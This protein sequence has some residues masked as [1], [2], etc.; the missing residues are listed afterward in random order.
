MKT[1]KDLEFKSITTGG[2]FVNS[3]ELKQEAINWVKEDIRD[4]SLTKGEIFPSEII[5]RWIKRLNLTEEDLK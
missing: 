5:E 2:T 1:L 4:L 3:E